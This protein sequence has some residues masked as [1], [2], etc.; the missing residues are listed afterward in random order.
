[1]IPEEQYW[2]VEVARELFGTTGPDIWLPWDRP[3]IW[4]IIVVVVLAGRGKAV[5]DLLGALARLAQAIHT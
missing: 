4:T 5:A 3:I 1:M 2:L